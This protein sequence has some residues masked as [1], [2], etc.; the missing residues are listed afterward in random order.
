MKALETILCE[1]TTE[2]LSRDKARKLLQAPSLNLMDAISPTT[3]SS[4]YLHHLAGS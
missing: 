3:G 4:L 2:K 1:R